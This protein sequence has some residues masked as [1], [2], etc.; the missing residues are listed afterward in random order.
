MVVIVNT[1]Q[2]SDKSKYLAESHKHRAVH[3]AQRRYNETG[4][5]QTG[6]DDNQQHSGTQLHAT[7]FI[8]VLHSLF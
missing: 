3:L 2:G 4:N 7:F 6:T 5:Q 1:K 8:L